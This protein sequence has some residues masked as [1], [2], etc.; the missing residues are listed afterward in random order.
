MNQEEEDGHC[1]A[2]FIDSL[3]KRGMVKNFV[4]LEI[5]LAVHSECWST[6]GNEV[7]LF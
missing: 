4:M 1:C 6:E 5:T 7:A 3:R 2:A